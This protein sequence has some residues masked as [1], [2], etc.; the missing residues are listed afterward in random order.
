V[1]FVTPGVRQ[2]YGPEGAGG[3]WDEFYWILEGARLEEWRRL[4]WWPEPARFW[5]LPVRR[6]AEAWALFEAGRGA[7]ERREAHGLDRA[8]LALERWLAE[9]PWSRAAS[10]GPGD[11]VSPVSR[12]VEAWR[13]DLARSWDLRECARQAGLSYTRFRARFRE[14][15]GRSPHAHLTD[16]RLELARRWLRA[17]DE[18]VK[19]VA[20]RCGFGGAESFIRAFARAHG[21]T[22][23]RWRAQ[24]TASG[25]ARRAARDEA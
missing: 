22:P 25:G 7:L 19:A 12:V 8:K 11:V 9:G 3:A 14:E 2:D 1:F 5:P 23:G 6:A 4:G 20:L 15:R 10:A 16:L 21:T 24:Q 13:R 17:T 18:P